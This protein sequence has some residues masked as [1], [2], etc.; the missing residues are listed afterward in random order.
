MDMKLQQAQRLL[1][2]EFGEFLA[3][4]AA[5]QRGGEA[6]LAARGR[7]CQGLLEKMAQAEV[8]RFLRAEI[9]VKR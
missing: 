2:D 6:V 1:V 5:Q 9:A 7:K 8:N 3:N 4:P